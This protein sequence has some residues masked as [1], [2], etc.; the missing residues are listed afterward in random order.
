[1]SFCLSVGSPDFQKVLKEI[2]SYEWAEI[3]L[4]LCHFSKE[5]ITRIAQSHG[6]LI[7]T[8]RSNV[9]VDDAK[10]LDLLSHAIESGAAYVDID[11]RN[12]ESFRMKIKE[13]ID[14]S[15]GCKLL[16]SYHNFDRMPCN[17]FLF[18]QILEM[19]KIEADLM[20]LVCTS[21]G[22]R[23]NKRI[24][25]FNESFENILAFNMGESGKQTRWKC[26]QFGAP[27]TYVAMEGDP[28]AAG[29]M[30]RQEMMKNI[31]K[32]VK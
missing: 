22:E 32:E 15:D 8:F 5:E 19:G 18:D 12:Q 16:M 3:R 30:T 10:R 25:A 27:F 9:E 23:D 6:H 14:L 7:F 28:T 1:M 26:L 17:H 20:K 4:D 2:Q 11:I 13:R 29:Q 21:H 24:L 31:D